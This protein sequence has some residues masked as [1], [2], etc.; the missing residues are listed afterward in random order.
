M[1][2]VD[3]GGQYSTLAVT[4]YDGNLGSDS[5]IFYRLYKTKCSYDSFQIDDVL[6]KNHFY[7]MCILYILQICNNKITNE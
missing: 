4:N 5:F 7:F 6:Y 3:D 2:V 1:L